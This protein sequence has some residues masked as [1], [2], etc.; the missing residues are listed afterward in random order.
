VTFAS[1]GDVVENSGEVEGA[2]VKTEAVSAVNSSDA[3]GDGGGVGGG[4][5]EAT[6]L[7][8]RPGR[9]DGCSAENGNGRKLLGGSRDSMS[10]KVRCVGSGVDAVVAGSGVDAVVAGAGV[11]AV[12]VG[13]GVGAVVGGSG[14][15]A[16]VGGSG[17]GA[18]AGT[19][20]GAAGDARAASGTISVA[21]SVV[22]AEPGPAVTV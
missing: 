10:K 22:V 11:G 6:V 14:V 20:G 21:I 7:A 16:V 1:C 3:S 12:V 2:A 4:D 15:G 9:S 13:S 18:G 8:S 19:G 5:G 17:G